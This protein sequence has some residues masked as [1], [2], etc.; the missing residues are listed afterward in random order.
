MKLVSIIGDGIRT[1]LL[2]KKIISPKL[3]LSL[4]FGRP[5]KTDHKKIICNNT[6][7]FRV[8]YTYAVI[9]LLT[10]QLFD[11]LKIPAVKPIIVAKTIPNNETSRVL[12]RPTSIALPK[13]A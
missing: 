4:T 2:F 3:I 5:V 6:G 7:T 13:V 1:P 8:N 11:N 12:S 9:N 10:N